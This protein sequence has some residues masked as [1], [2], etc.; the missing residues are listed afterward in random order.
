MHECFSYVYVCPSYA[1]LVP[2]GKKKSL[3]DAKKPLLGERLIEIELVQPGVMVFTP[4][5]PARR[6]LRQCQCLKPAA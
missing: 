4:I 3:I 5:I 1:Y 2:T 6:R